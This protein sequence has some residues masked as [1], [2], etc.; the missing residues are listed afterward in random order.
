[1]LMKTNRSSFMLKPILNKENWRGT[2]R[3]SVIDQ[4]ILWE[5]QYVAIEAGT[6]GFY[7]PGLHIVNYKKD[8]KISCYKL[9]INKDIVYIPVD[10]LETCTSP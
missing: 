4:D 3:Y 2:S 9:L 5:L 6:V 10:F 8:S 7:L 1:M